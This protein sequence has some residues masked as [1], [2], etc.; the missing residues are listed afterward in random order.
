MN[1]KD[2]LRKGDPAADDPGMSPEEIQAMRR[3]VLSAVPEPRRRGWLIPVAVG[4]ALILAALIGL[5]L[6]RQPTQPTL[7]ASEGRAVAPSPAQ[8]G[9]GGEGASSPAPKRPLPFPLPR[10]GA[11]EG[12]SHP[13]P[14]VKVA[15]VHPRPRPRSVS[16]PEPTVEVAK[17]E[18]QQQI[19]FSTPGGTRIIWVLNR[20]AD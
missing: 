14:D 16:R 8:R 6:W 19:Q 15:R 10:Q 5:T 7:L 17:V 13:S 9:R 11:G 2:V 3:T 18:T 1:L 12:T 20:T 4:A